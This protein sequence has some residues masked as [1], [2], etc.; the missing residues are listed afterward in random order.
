MKRRY[1]LKIAIPTFAFVVFIIA[2]I[3]IYAYS[4]DTRVDTVER[5]IIET[6]ISKSDFVNFNNISNRERE[7]L[8][9]KVMEAAQKISGPSRISPPHGLK[10]GIALSL[11]YSGGSCYDRSFSVEQILT[12]LDIPSRHV[13]LA[14]DKTSS[15]FKLGLLSHALTEVNIDGRWILIESLYPHVYKNKSGELVDALFIKK[16]PTDVILP[17]FYQKDIGLYSYIGRGDFNVYYG[18]YSRHGGFFP[19]YHIPFNINY[20][21]ILFNF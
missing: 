9:L 15:I 7:L 13:F 14:M 20:K 16:N 1:N 4:V 17:D 6:Y 12:Y 5:E 21:Q 19:P 3:Y 18:I 11:K 2:S 8:L 10:R